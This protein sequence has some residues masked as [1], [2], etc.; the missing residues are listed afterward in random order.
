VAFWSSQGFDFDGL[1]VPRSAE[2]VRRIGFG[3]SDKETGTLFAIADQ[4]VVNLC[5]FGG[6]GDALWSAEKAWKDHRQVIGLEGVRTLRLKRLHTGRHA[7]RLERS[8]VLVLLRGRQTGVIV[9]D[10]ITGKR[11]WSVFYD[12]VLLGGVQ[13][14]P[15]EEDGRR[16]VLLGGFRGS[17]FRAEPVLLV[18]G[19]DGVVRQQVVLPVLMKGRMREASVEQILANWRTDPPR[20]RLGLSGNLI[21]GFDWRD[22]RLDLTSAGVVES[23]R[24][25]VD[26][27]ARYDD[28]II[29]RH[30]AEYGG[31]DRWPMGIAAAIR[32]EQGGVSPGWRGR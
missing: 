13:T 14:M 3:I 16:P 27:Q 15:E 11:H 12:G 23:D 21:I 10:P 5:A 20:V 17:G 30:F 4:G 22:G 8:F 18:V 31:P 7:G 32:E 26:L 1:G 19:G 9:G 29:R 24:L 2:V 6:R 28:E 25:L